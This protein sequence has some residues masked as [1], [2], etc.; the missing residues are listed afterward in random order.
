MDLATKGYCKTFIKGF[1]W[2]TLFREFEADNAPEECRDS[3]IGFEVPMGDC[4]EIKVTAKG[5][6]DHK[7]LPSIVQFVVIAACIVVDIC[8]P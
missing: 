2:G 4:K 6:W 8:F 5:L 1:L 7:K 3:Q